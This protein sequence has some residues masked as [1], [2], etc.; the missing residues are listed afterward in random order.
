[1]SEKV[2]CAERLHEAL[3]LRNL[4]QADLCAL[5]G[6][7]KSA[8]SQYL[9]G[10]FE[11]KQDRVELLARALG[12]TEAWLMGYDFPMEGKPEGVMG[13]GIQAQTSHLIAQGFT[14]EQAQ[15]YGFLEKFYYGTKEKQPAAPEDD[16]L[17]PLLNDPNIAKV[18]E[19]FRQLSPE[20]QK[21]ALAQLDFLTKYQEKE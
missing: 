17:M 4:R 21:L 6:I 20:N 10:A 12:V 2:T 15:D 5:T 18:L 19:L 3:R 8:M 7:P 11:P 14:L 1:M 16:E 9:S 13:S